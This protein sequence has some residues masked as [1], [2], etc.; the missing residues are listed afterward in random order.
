MAAAGDKKKK[1]PSKT[2]QE[3]KKELERK[4]KNKQ[5]KIPNKSVSISGFTVPEGNRKGETA[6]SAKCISY[7]YQM[8]RIFH[9]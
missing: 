8:H 5:Q 7:V 9:V 3:Q 1:H 4:Q 2:L 6:F